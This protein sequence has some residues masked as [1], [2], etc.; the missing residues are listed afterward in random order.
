MCWVSAAWQ[1]GGGRLASQVV[2]WTVAGR[3]GETLS[4]AWLSGPASPIFRARLGGRC[5]GQRKSDKGSSSCCVLPL[6]Q[7]QVT[8]PFFPSRPLWRP[9]PAHT[10]SR[11][12]RLCRPPKIV[13][14]SLVFLCPLSA[15]LPRAPRQHDAALSAYSHLCSIRVSRSIPTEPAHPAFFDLGCLSVYL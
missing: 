1:G 9:A 8:A 4:L 13:P 12:G 2:Q 11:R 6:R 3:D 5:T 14:C 15:S 7:E 10:A